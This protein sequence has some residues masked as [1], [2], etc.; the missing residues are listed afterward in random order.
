MASGMLRRFFNAFPDSLNTAEDAAVNTLAAASRH[1]AG[2]DIKS[3]AGVDSCAAYLNAVEATATQLQIPP[4]QRSYRASFPL[5]YRSLFPSEARSYR[6]DVLEASLEHYNVIWVNGEK[7]EFSA[8]A[9][10]RAEE[11]QVAW[12][13]LGT[14]LERWNRSRAGS[15][16]NSPRPTR[17]DLT[18]VLKALDSAWASFEERYISELV[19]IEAKARGHI[20]QAIELERQL[21]QLEMQYG[22][23][24]WKI[25]DYREVQRGLV[26]AVARLNSVANVNRK[27]RDDLRVE[28]LQEAH[29]ALRQCNAAGDIGQEAANL[30]TATKILSTD[31]VDSFEAMRV[32]LR[33]VANQ[34][35]RVD[36]H[37]GNNGGLVN[38]LVDWEE[39]WEV[40]TSYLQQKRVLHALCDAVAE[41]HRVQSFAPK[42]ADMCEECDVEL[43]MVLPRLMWL[44]FLVEPEQQMPLLARLLPHRF[45]AASSE[46]P[47]LGQDL[48]SFSEKYARAECALA[49]LCGTA[50]HPEPLFRGLGS[51]ADARQLLAKRVICGSDDETNAVYAY[52][53]IHDAHVEEAK[54]QVEDLMHE[55]E[56]WSIELQRHCPEDWNQYSAVLVH[57]LRTEAEKER[58]GPFGV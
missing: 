46:T 13:D 34:L 50:G 19:Q 43:F 41:I 48:R 35:E 8:E 58:K 39:S 26:T 42:L 36:P 22:E 29:S 51:T 49:R 15:H 40:G 4:T 9:T 44:R 28:V 23:E 16:D 38:R 47:T 25:P 17:Q 57:C 32:Y 10:K 6:A 2:L 30:L 12:I 20:V 27:G 3:S 33:D 54:A 56:A 53:A 18:S 45:G 14:M 21:K 1:A 11:L 31:V 7:F 5:N 52:A 37:L 24:A 55:L